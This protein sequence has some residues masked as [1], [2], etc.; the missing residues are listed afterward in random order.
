LQYTNNNN[1]V[2]GAEALNGGS[3]SIAGNYFLG[4]IGYVCVYDRA[5][6]DN[7]VKLLF[8]AHRGRYGI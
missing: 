5:L 7:E 3:N 6:S 8:N 2:V 1:L 4:N